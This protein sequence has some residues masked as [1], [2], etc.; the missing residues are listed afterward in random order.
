MEK[1]E[2]FRRKTRYFMAGEPVSPILRSVLQRCKLPISFARKMSRQSILAGSLDFISH[3]CGAKHES[4]AIR[5]NNEKQSTGHR[6]HDRGAG[7]RV[8]ACPSTESDRRSFVETLQYSVTQFTKF[9]IQKMAAAEEWQDRGAP[10]FDL[11]A[12]VH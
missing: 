3:F 10:L 12:S 8:S 7:G 6:I 4:G 9:S 1:T 5:A 11:A 2:G